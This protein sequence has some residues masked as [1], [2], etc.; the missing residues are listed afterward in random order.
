[1]KEMI[2]QIIGSRSFDETVDRVQENA[3]S[4]GFGV[5][6][7]HDVQATLAGKG[8]EHGPLKIVEVCNPEYAYTALG[9]D[10]AASLLMPCRINVRVDQ[11]QT[12]ITTLL[13]SGL[14]GNLEN[15]EL[16]NLGRKIDEGLKRIVDDSI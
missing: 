7:I 12:V 13:P 10:A 9:V 6:H 2:Y 15:T 1:M 5:L 14:I 16:S 4:Q 8:L 11:D 3:K